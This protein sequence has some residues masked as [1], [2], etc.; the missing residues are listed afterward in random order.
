[1]FKLAT[2][3]V[4]QENQNKRCSAT[5]YA[6]PSYR[7]A[8]LKRTDHRTAKERTRVPWLDLSVRLSLVCEPRMPL[9]TFLTVAVSRKEG[10]RARPST[11]STIQGRELQC[12][13]KDV[14]ARRGIYL[15]VSFYTFFFCF[16]VLRAKRRCSQNNNVC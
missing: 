9:R 4:D 16:V 11:E 2:D 13:L 10:Q 8:V 5:L 15:A 14:C 1:M 12:C 3:P 7:C 6:H